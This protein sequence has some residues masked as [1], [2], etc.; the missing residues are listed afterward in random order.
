MKTRLISSLLVTLFLLGCR[1]DNDPS[2]LVMTECV[3]V[4]QYYLTNQSTRSLSVDFI[5]HVDGAI[6]PATLVNSQQTTLIGQDS[7][8]GAIPKPAS[9]FSSVTLSTV[10]DEKI[11]V[12]Y[13]QSPVRN[14]L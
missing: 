3:G 9:T 14:E 2:D 8:F 12:I 5:G 7:R 13:T 10:T 1:Q 6:S 11:T 4:T